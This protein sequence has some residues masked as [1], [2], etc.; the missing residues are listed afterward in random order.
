[1]PVSP[2][3]VL[4]GLPATPTLTPYPKSFPAQYTISKYYNNGDNGD[5]AAAAAA[6]AE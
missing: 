5:A 2:I 3:T 4:Q 1:M 6:A